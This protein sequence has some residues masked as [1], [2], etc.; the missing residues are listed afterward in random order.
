[1][2]P[3]EKENWKCNKYYI[4][5]LFLSIL[6]LLVSPPYCEVIYKKYIDIRDAANGDPNV[7]FLSSVFTLFGFSIIYV[8]GTLLRTLRN[9]YI[10]TEEEFK[11]QIHVMSEERKYFSQEKDLINE[12][13]EK[14]KE[15]A[16]NK[17]EGKKI[18]NLLDRIKDI[19]K[20]IK[21]VQD[22]L[23]VLNRSI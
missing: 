3:T 2:E 6:L 7:Q 19:K 11:E 10:K 21:D 14:E 5:A 22:K 9:N 16:G 13:R 15:L 4:I 20:Q 17:Y 23:S 18:D 12:L 8:L 1:M